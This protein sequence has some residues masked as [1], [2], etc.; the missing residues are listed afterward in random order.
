MNAPVMVNLDGE[1]DPLKIAQK[2][3]RFAR[4]LVFFSYLTRVPLF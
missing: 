3:L 2:E 4:L 1:T